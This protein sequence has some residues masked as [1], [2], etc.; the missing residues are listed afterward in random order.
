MQV[1][2][3]EGS[4]IFLQFP[5]CRLARR[6]ARDHLA[7]ARQAIAFPQIARP[8]GG[9]DILP[10]SAPTAGTRDHMVKGQIRRGIATAAI[11]TFKMIAQKDIEAR[12]GRAPRGGDK[13][14]ERNHAGQA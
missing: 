2:R 11:L 10:G 13:L 3:R 8:A 7:F 4:S 14:L 1:I 9:D 12:E 5:A 6:L